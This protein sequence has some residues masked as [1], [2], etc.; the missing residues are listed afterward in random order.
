MIISLLIKTLQLDQSN[1]EWHP[2]RRRFFSKNSWK[3]PISLSNGLV[4]QW[5]GQP[6]LTNAFLYR[7]FQLVQ[8]VTVRLLEPGT[9]KKII[10]SHVLWK[11]KI[12]KFFFLQTDQF[13][14]DR[15]QII[16]VAKKYIYVCVQFHNW[17]IHEFEG[18]FLRGQ[19][20]SNGFKVFNPVFNS[21]IVEPWI[22]LVSL[23][24]KLENL[25]FSKSFVNG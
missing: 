25:L 13:K 11:Q 7:L 8:F 3:T 23:E 2:P 18:C 19:V 21:C 1:P 14:V 15:L 20:S 6:V 12:L 4:G 5:S 10:Q 24:K 17:F 22:L 16:V 9:W